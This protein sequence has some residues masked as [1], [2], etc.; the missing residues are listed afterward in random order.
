[1]LYLGKDE[2]QAGVDCPSERR[3]NGRWLRTSHQ[4]GPWAVVALQFRFGRGRTSQDEAESI[5][6]EPGIRGVWP[7]S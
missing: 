4:H 6:V 7:I 5:Q 3:V 1:M 2:K